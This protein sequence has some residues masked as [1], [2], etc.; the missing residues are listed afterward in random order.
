MS[1]QDDITFWR[2]IL[3]I[4]RINNPNPML[5]KDY[6][7]N[8]CTEEF[9]L[10]PTIQE[11]MCPECDSEDIEE[12]PEDMDEDEEKEEEDDGEDY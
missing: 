2:N 11:K 6:I 5:E 8:D 10:N 9:T 4:E 3:G 12:I 1:V 7:C